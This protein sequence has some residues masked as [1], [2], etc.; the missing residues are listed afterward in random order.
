MYKDWK[1]KIKLSLSTD[2]VII[3]KLKKIYLQT[4]FYNFC[5]RVQQGCCLQMITQESPTFNIQLQMITKCTFKMS[6]IVSTENKSNKNVQELY[7]D[8]QKVL[9]NDVK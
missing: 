7:G 3:N 8:N 9:L 2:D 4:P 5:E 6:F 1:G